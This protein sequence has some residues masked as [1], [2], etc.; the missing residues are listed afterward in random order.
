MR[1][2]SLNGLPAQAGQGECPV[3]LEFSL[4]RVS[5]LNW[6]GCGCMTRGA[7]QAWHIG[8]PAVFTLKHAA[9]PSALKRTPHSDHGNV[10]ARSA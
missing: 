9:P 5:T 3:V 10:Q 1:S 4:I 6:H 2:T 7:R 8:F